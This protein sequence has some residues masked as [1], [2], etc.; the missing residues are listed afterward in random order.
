MRG[1]LRDPLTSASY[2]PIVYV[3]GVPQVEVD[4]HTEEGAYYIN[5]QTGQITFE[6]PVPEGTPVV[7]DYYYAQ[8]STFKV[9]PNPGKLLNL[10]QA[11][12]QFSDDLDMRDTLIF[13]VYVG[14]YPYG[15][16][17]VFN[18]IRDFFVDAQRSNPSIPA[19]GN[20]LNWRASSKATLPLVWDYL[21]NKGFASCMAVELRLTLVHHE[22]FGGSY[23][24]ASFYCHEE[25][26]G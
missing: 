8:G 23:A 9:T 14:G 5:Y 17:T 4:P 12:V 10:S 25:E 2:T 13:Q 15:P 6:T 11:K 1:V 18:T 3:D 21:G 22:P 19:L 20:P 24:T 7:V 26:E 16:S